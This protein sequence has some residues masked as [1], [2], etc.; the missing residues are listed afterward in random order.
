MRAA[1]RSR[2][3][4]AGGGGAGGGAAEH[5]STSTH[6]CLG[7]LSPLCFLL[8]LIF[9]VFNVFPRLQSNKCFGR[10][11]RVGIGTNYALFALPCAGGGE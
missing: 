2:G 5:C 9:Y 10:R 1:G 11:C 4:C 3:G 8:K 7:F 6:K